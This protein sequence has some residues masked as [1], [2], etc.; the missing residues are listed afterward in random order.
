M[1]K[2]RPTE[3][4][5]EEVR[6]ATNP[7]RNSTRQTFDR[8]KY[9]RWRAYRERCPDLALEVTFVEGLVRWLGPGESQAR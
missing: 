5:R 7:L 6:C 3:I 1:I 9:D 8:A 4:F 2:P